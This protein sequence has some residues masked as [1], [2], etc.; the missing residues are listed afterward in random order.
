MFAGASISA[1][2]KE[3]HTIYKL[4]NNKTYI[5]MYS[6]DSVHV[7]THTHTHR[8]RNTTS[9]HLYSAKQIVFQSMSMLTIAENYV[10]LVAC[11]YMHP[12]ANI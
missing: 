12:G 10:L 3:S 6:R 5:K 9:K 4:I 8:N 11:V 2:H 1:L 7:H